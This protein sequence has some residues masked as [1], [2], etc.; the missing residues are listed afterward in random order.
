VPRQQFHLCGHRP[1]RRHTTFWASRVRIPR[2]IRSAPCIAAASTTSHSSRS[3]PRLANRQSP[4]KAHT[5]AG[6]CSG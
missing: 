1:R 5:L 4:S 6:W 3:T 2:P